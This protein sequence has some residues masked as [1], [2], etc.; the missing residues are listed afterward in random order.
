MKKIL[1]LFFAAILFGCVLVACEGSNSE[2]VGSWVHI[3]HD[4]EYTFNSNGSGEG[5]LEG[6][7]EEFNWETSDG[8]LTITFI[9][10][11]EGTGEFYVEYNIYND[12]LTFTYPSGSEVTFMRKRD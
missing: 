4:Y 2:L 3:T 1:G 12:I 9:E 5:R 7:T 8:I 11:R 10:D 6:S